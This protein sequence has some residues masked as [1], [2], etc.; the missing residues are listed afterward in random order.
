MFNFLDIL[1][2]VGYIGIFANYDARPGG[3]YFPQISKCVRLSGIWEYFHLPLIFE[4]TKVIISC[5]V[6]LAFHRR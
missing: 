3:V 5:T 1:R 2:I 6:P 4:F